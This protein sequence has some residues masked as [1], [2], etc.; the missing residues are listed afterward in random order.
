MSLLACPAGTVVADSHC[1]TQY[2]R[3][4]GDLL[5]RACNT[6]PCTHHTWRVSVLGE[7]VCTHSSTFAVMVP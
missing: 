1:I 3:V 4:S 5:R 7:A 2:G 6:Q